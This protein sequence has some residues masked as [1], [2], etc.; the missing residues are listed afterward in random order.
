MMEGVDEA[1][2][3]FCVYRAN[4]GHIWQGGHGY[5]DDSLGRRCEQQQSAPG[6]DDLPRTLVITLR[7]SCMIDILDGPFGTTNRGCDR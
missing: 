3:G 5:W 1:S 7:G 6:Y 2:H 4:M